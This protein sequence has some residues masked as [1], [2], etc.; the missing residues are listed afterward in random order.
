M[1]LKE[2]IY[3]IDTYQKSLMRDGIDNSDIEEHIH[4]ISIERAGL[5]NELR[6][7]SEMRNSLKHN[8][9]ESNDLRNYASQK[10]LFK[11]FTNKEKDDSKKNN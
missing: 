3:Q 11:M 10:D 5:Q 8:D 1:K 2:N 7:I 9:W 6:E 4:N